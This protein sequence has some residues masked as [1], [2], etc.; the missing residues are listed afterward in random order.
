M[1][2]LLAILFCSV[3]ISV[4]AVDF[5]PVQTTTPFASM[6]SVNNSSYMSTGSTYAPVVHD[7][8]AYS[9]TASGPLRAKAGFDDITT[10][11]ETEE[12]GYDPN[13][14]QFSPLGDAL[15]PLLLMVMAYAAY[16]LLR[17][18]RSRV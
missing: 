1:K 10:G 8:G 7:V 15:I 12:G 5:T 17:R 14:P 9:P 4:Y 18:R 3:G 16:T 2:Q 13:N 6:Q 11:E